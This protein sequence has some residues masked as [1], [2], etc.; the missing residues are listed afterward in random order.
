MQVALAEGSM[1]TKFELDQR[2]GSIVEAGE[3]RLLNQEN[4]KRLQKL[5]DKLAQRD[6]TI[7][8]LNIRAQDLEQ[9]LSKLRDAFT[10]SEANVCAARDELT[11]TRSDLQT[12]CA[13]AESLRQLLKVRSCA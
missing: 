5:S 9:E 1:H 11:Q 8:R 10:G 12:Q 13:E 2:A 3:L 7:V 4:S 6:K